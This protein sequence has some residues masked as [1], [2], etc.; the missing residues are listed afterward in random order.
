MLQVMI[1]TKIIPN[2][3][4]VVLGVYAGNDRGQ[5]LFNKRYDDEEQGW[6][7]IK[8]ISGWAIT[9]ARY[10]RQTDNDEVEEMILQ[11]ESVKVEGNSV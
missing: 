11:A 1:L 4:H 8:T 5:E 10:Q 9:G 7:R 6:N 3:Q 2:H